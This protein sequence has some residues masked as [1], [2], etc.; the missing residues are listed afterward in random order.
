MSIDNTS[1]LIIGGTGTLGVA[2]LNRLHS[3]GL[4][5]LSIKV[6]SRDEQKQYRLKKQFPN[7]DFVLG[8][9]KDI[10]SLA[11]HFKGIDH[12]FHFAAL[13][14]IDILESFPEECI[15]TNIG[16]TLN[17]I[18][19]ARASAVKDF[20]FSST[21]KAVD[22]I[23]VY[24]YCKAISEKLVLN[25]NKYPSTNFTVFRWGN[26]INSNGSALPFFIDKIKKGEEVP[27]THANMSRFFIT[28]ENAVDFMISK[29]EEK[30]KE[31]MV[32]PDMKAAKI[33]DVIKLIANMLDKPYSIK[34]VGLRP[35]EKIS[36]CLYSKHSGKYVDSETCPQ[37]TEQELIELIRPM[38]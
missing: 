37:Y 28:I 19:C 22:P 30:S 1:I 16:G 27:L 38:L 15:K 4:G 12:V 11:P 23:N 3:I 33:I 9:I 14:H 26:I 6:L 29:F 10:H 24:G 5:N 35:G 36:E 2:L 21:D 18:S 31:P 7:V 34:I 25:A 17:S 13:K 32:H 8:D 20:V